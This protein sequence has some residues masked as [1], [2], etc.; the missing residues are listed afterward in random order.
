MTNFA[1][2][3]RV[4]YFVMVFISLCLIYSAKISAGSTS[5]DRV[6][7]FVTEPDHK[8]ILENNKVRFVELVVPKGKTT[9]FHEHRHDVFVVFYGDCTVMNEPYGG[10]APAAKVTAG[11]VFFNSVEKGPYIHRV[12]AAGEKTIHNMT[13]ELLSSPKQASEHSEESRFP[14]YQ[15][16]LENSRGRVYRLKLNPGESTDTFTR[17]VGTAVFAISS[18]R[19]S[20]KPEG[21]QARLWDF[22]PGYVKWTDTSEELSIKN[23][24]Q[25]PIELV[26]IEVL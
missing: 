2:S 13:L 7:P 8:A 22:K 26:E 14:P 10:K 6:V 20:E 15:L 11:S 21:K 12:V 1:Q 17:P 5:T 25:I 9:L 19:I 18:G 4:N 16:V 23:E 3:I 24:S